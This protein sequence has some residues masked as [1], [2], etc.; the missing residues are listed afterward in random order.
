MPAL[1]LNMLLRAEGI[2]PQGVMVFRHRPTEPKLRKAFR[3][4]IADRRELFD[5][6]QRTHS[7]R[8]ERSLARASHVAA[9]FGHE[10][11]KAMF[12]GLYRV[13][14]F[15]SISRD[16]YWA[17]HEHQKLAEL[18]MIGFTERDQ[19]LLFELEALSNMAEWSG[20]LVCDWPGKEL[21][22]WRWAERN[23][24]GVD[25]I[26]VES[27]LIEPVPAWDDVVLD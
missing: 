3:R 14:G 20:R 2:D 21:S 4:I 6:Y 17:M 19:C 13:A 22:W 5:A 11:Q 7:E 27:L 24:I 18:G 15:T 25:A 16:G 12:V 10:P 8:V 1:D 26:S 23:S 9:F